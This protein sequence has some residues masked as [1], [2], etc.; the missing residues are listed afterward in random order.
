[1]CLVPSGRQLAE[2]EPTK[3]R[4]TPRFPHFVSKTRV[5]GKTLGSLCESGLDLGHLNEE[6]EAVWFVLGIYPGVFILAV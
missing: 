2:T 6:V 4:S 5:L 3:G 1:M